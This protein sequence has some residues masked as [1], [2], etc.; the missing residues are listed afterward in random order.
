MS[1]IYDQINKYLNNSRLYYKNSLTHYHNRA[2][3]KASECLWGAIVETLKALSLIKRR[4]PVNSHGDIA[5]FLDSLIEAGHDAGNITA[6]KELKK[7]ANDLH[8]YFY[9]T[10]LSDVDFG[11]IFA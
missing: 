7:A 10:Y 6:M 5:K 9:E 11:E 8:V 3:P 1:E 2:F 4:K